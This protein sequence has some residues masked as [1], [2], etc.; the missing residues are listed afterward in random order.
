MM[1]RRKNDDLQGDSPRVLKVNFLK[2]KL[3]VAEHIG[4]DIVEIFFSLS[5]KARSSEN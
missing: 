1:L 5:V 2:K 3:G 4:A